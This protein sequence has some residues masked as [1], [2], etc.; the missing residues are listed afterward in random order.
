MSVELSEEPAVE[1]SQRP[2]TRGVTWRSFLLGTLTVIAICALTPL[3]DFAFSNTSLAAGFM[4]LAGV[5]TL[6]LFVVVVNAPLHRWFPR[7]ALSS[8]ELAVIV[9]MSF[10]ACGMS[11]WGLMRFFIPTPVAP[12]HVGATD[13]TYW[14][15]FVGM[16]LPNWLFPVEDLKN[17]RTSPI[18]RWFYSHVPE[19]EKIP[20]RAWI[21]PLFAWGVFLFAMLATLAAIARLTFEQWASNERLP[22]PLVQVQSALLEAPKKGR[23]LN[24]IFRSN[25]FWIGLG[26]A[27][28][29]QALSCLNTYFPRNVPKI[30]LSYDF[31]ALLSEPPLFYLNAKLKRAALSFTVVGVTFFIRSRVAFSLWIFFIITNLVEVQYGMR[32]GEMPGAAWQDQHLGACVAFVGAIAWIGRHHWLRVLKSAVGLARDRVHASAFWVAT[33][34]TIV[35]VAWLKIV[36]VQLLVA[37]GIV[38]FILTAHLVVARVVAE[39]GLPFYRS[40]VAVAQ[41]QSL[42]P[43]RWFGLRDIFFSCMFT[44]LGPITSR[45]SVTAFTQQGLGLCRNAGVGEPPL[46]IRLDAGA[47]RARAART[48]LGAVIGWSLVVGFIVGAFSTIYCQY[49]YP[50]PLAAD[51]VP[52]RNYFGAEYIPKREVANPFDD[53]SRGRFTQRQHNPYVHMS[54]GFVV[55]CGLEAAAMYWSGWPLLPVGYVASYGAFI[56]NAWF[57]IFIGWLAQLVV[58]RLGGASLFQRARPFFIGI[59]FGE[60][61]VAGIWLIVNAIIV[62]NGGESQ[63]VKFLL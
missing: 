38:A 32:Q 24:E 21:T 7:A 55:T 19:G 58:V 36:G 22:F 61:L 4:P 13:E 10:I 47:K 59:I 49:S 6:F 14:K 33:I 60:G 12:F 27:F 50:T 28:F 52:A 54:I 62:L 9:L 31:S 43:T 42:M 57:S 11:N 20:F 46:A 51:Q 41:V 48:H 35:M 5:L 8:G 1:L 40:G 44:V 29:V 23:A 53:F 34:G 3:N 25:V 2:K 37:L 56:G 39:T 45:D 30:P 26:V 17:G 15:A 63:A 16:D 18:A